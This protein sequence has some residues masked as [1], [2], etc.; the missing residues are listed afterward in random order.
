MRQPAEQLPPRRVGEDVRDWL[1]EI[2]AQHR[3]RF[4]FI[5]VDDQP[6]GPWVAIVD[7]GDPEATHAVALVGRS[8][9]EWP[10]AATAAVCGFMVVPA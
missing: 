3:V 5:P 8:S 6:A 9:P 10:R 7:T 4:E 1:G 2:E